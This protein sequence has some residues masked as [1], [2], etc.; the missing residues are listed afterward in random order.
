VWADL[1]LLEYSKV[2]DQQVANRK[3][4]ADRYAELLDD[5]GAQDKA[6][7][8]LQSKVPVPRMSDLFRSIAG[9]LTS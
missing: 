2:R 6:S 9:V 4:L 5:E 1:Q 3:R 8:E 7:K